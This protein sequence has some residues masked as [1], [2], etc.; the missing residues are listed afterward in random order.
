MRR[1][2]VLLCSVALVGVTA[3]GASPAGA[4]TS[5]DVNPSTAVNLGWGFLEET[6]PG[7]G[8]FELGPATPPD[9]VGSARIT[10]GAN[11]GMAF[12]MIGYGGTRLDEISALG[13]STY[14]SSSDAGN[15]LAASM[16]MVIDYDVTDGNTVY[17]GRLVFSPSDTAPGGVPQDTWQ[18]W[19]AHAGRWYATGAPGNTAC[20]SSSRCTWSEILTSF[21]D[22][23][24]LASPFYGGVLFKAGAWSSAFEG[25]V[26]AFSITTA[27]NGTDT[28]DFEPLNT[29][30]C[31][32]PHAEDLVGVRYRSFGNTGSNEV[33]A[34]VPDLGATPRAEAGLSWLSGDNTFS[35]TYSPATGL[36]TTVNA[37]TPLT[38]SVAQITSDMA[39]KGKTLTLGDLNVMQVTVKNQSNVLGPQPSVVVKDLTV[40]GVPIDGDTGTPATI[41]DLTGIA[42]TTLDWMLTGL[43]FADGFTATGTIDLDPGTGFGASAE[44]SRVEVGVGHYDDTVT[45]DV[46]DASVAEVPGTADVSITATG[47][48]LRPVEFLASTADVSATAGSDYTATVAPI[49]FQPCSS[50]SEVVS[51]P[52]LT[53]ALIEGTETFSLALSQALGATIG[54]G[55]GT[56]SILDN[57]GFRISDLTV[58]E[59][60]AGVKTVV[61]FSVNL[62]QAQPT[63][64]T[65]NYVTV[66]GTATPGYDYKHKGPKTLKFKAGQTTKPVTIKILG[67]TDPEGDETFSVV[68]SGSSGPLIVDGTGIATILNDDSPTAVTP[69][70]RVSDAEVWE[71]D[72]GIK[73]KVWV[74]LTLSS[75]SV[76]VVTVSTA[77]ADGTATVAGL[78]YKAKSPKVITF[79]PGQTARRVGITYYPDTS[80]EGDETFDLVLSSPSGAL[81]ADGTGTVTIRNEDV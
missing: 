77:T 35:I 12:G 1:L 29:T 23:G 74:T 45:L 34:G 19:D 7:S 33:Y 37:G 36:S 63:P 31:F 22:A 57:D 73:N 16:Q 59:G 67:D 40:D 54:D 13:Y 52:I 32:V 38:R 3:L 10:T 51:I 78:D 55:T 65:V 43:D 58:A 47:T 75:A 41:D 60:D 9:G 5:V 66:A 6:A 25:N 28:Y 76:G 24:I 49:V 53:D 72:L 80:I 27:A 15:N 64:T 2:F 68:L 14:R 20:P 48:R 4:S 50:D 79:K 62:S 44:G 46:G 56:V 42:G 26:D 30:T 81:I 8:D 71:G 18:T 17:Q 70:L 21:P 11:G 61:K 69:E 39:A